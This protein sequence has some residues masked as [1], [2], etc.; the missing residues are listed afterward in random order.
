MRIPF[1]Y[2]CIIIAAAFCL[3]SIELWQTE[4]P[5]GDEAHFIG[6]AMHH[7]TE[8]RI[9]INP[10]FAIYTIILKFISND[11]IQAHY[12]CR[13][14]VSCIASLLM[15]LF[16]KQFNF[17]KND[18]AILLV[19]AF[20]M[21]CRVNIPFSQFGNANLFAFI[22]VLSSFIPLMK[23]IN[24]LRISFFITAT[25]WAAQIRTEY[26]AVLILSL[27][28][29]S[30]RFSFNKNKIPRPATKEIL[31]TL[32]CLLMP[33]AS[34]IIIASK[35]DKA[36]EHD[37]FFCL[38][39]HYSSYYTR[40]HPGVKFHAMTEYGTVIN[41]VFRKPNSFWNAFANNPKEMLKFLTNNGIRNTCIAVP[42]LLRHRS[43]FIPR[44]Y[45][46]KGEIVE[47]GAILLILTAGIYLGLKQIGFKPQNLKTF[48]LRIIQDPRF[49]LMLLL[50]AAMGVPIL[51]L[52]PDP[53]YYLP[54]VPLLFLSMAWSIQQ[55][56]DKCRL[57]TQIIIT[58]MLGLWFCHPLFIG[59]PSNRDLILKMRE[60]HSS[61]QR[62][63]IAG[64]VPSF[65]ATFAFGNNHKLVYAG[66]ISL[67]AI[68]CTEY[69]FI[70]INKYFRNSAFWQKHQKFMKRFESDPERYGYVKLGTS[71]DKHQNTIYGKKPDA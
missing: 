53:R 63:V 67:V 39:Q 48:C 57:R 44:K 6:K 25:L 8:N 30:I 31:L 56:L 41:R 69:D 43:L 64:L 51:L 36:L 26:Y 29:F 60:H 42:G 58:V 50:T 38:K 49:I 19:C 13:I 24:C 34:I 46:K 21:C 55:L 17:L 18:L 23:K 66:K 52:I 27:M 65:V 61:E 22:L 68:E 12:C 4:L 2:S 40:T 7:N 45:G 10:Y 70:V 62:P 15:F 14:L 1:R 71:P 32:L 5:L 37:L 11:P 59:R 35:R 54:L 33:L 20:W 3:I 9:P 28:Y 16:L 47:I